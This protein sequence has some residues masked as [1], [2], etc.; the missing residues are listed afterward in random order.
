MRI[1]FIVLK[2]LSINLEK[3]NEFIERKEYVKYYS[4]KT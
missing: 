2:K 4:D 1:F 3:K